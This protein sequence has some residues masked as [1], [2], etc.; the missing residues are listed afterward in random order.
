MTDT[1]MQEKL[2]SKGFLTA[3]DAPEIDDADKGEALRI[4]LDKGLHDAEKTPYTVYEK[5]DFENGVIRGIIFN[6]DIIPTRDKAMDKLSEV[7]NQKEIKITEEAE[8]EI[9]DIGK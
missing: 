2:M 8:E 9:N 3:A 5:F 7:S 1:E 4:K 6:M